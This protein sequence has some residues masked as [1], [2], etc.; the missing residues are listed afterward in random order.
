MAESESESES[1]PTSRP[2]WTG[3]ISF[4]L[5]SIPV[6]LFTAVREKRLSFRSLHDQDQVPLKQ[7]L[8]C[9]AD[10][11]D[12]HPEH[13]VK[14]FE[15]EKDRYVVIRQEELEAVAPKATKAI[16]IQ[17]FVGL[18]EIDPVYFDRAYYVVP[19]PEGMRPYKLLLE[20]LTRKQKVGIARVVMHNKEY[21]AALRPLEN[22]LCLDTM[23]F[24]DEVVPAT[25]VHASDAAT[26]VD[27]RELK[28]AEQLVDSL[29]TEFKPSAYH[30]E[31]REKVMEL[32]DQKAK[33]EEPVMRPESDAAPQKGRDLMAALE[34]SLEKAKG[35]S[36][37]PVAAQE[38]GHGRRKKTG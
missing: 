33:G 4:G 38:K 5:V 21:L 12:V 20:A 8:Y 10:G 16:E 23:H 9:P 26:K 7:K 17:D 13:I 27:P 25:R 36:A 30:D 24:G 29:T 3:S 34:A 2:V 28:M 15:I 22:T 31:Y 11:K 1:T 19:K 35:Q 18:E 14:G 6:K 32:I 37:K